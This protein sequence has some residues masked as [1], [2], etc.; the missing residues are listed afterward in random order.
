M[1]KKA[2]DN[3]GHNAHFFGAIFGILFTVLLNTEILKNFIAEI[4][5]SLGLS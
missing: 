3:I 2:K 1:A 4:L 5:G